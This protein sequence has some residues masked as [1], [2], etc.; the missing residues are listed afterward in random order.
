MGRSQV[1]AE[2]RKSFLFSYTF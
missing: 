1:E 2:L